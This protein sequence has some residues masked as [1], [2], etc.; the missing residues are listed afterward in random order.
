[1]SKAKPYYDT[2]Y[3]LEVAKMVVE[4]GLTQSQVCQDLSISQSAIARWVRQY[5]SEARG[6]PG[7]GLPLTPEQQRIRALEIEVRQ[8]RE[9]NALLK[10]A[11]AFFA[12]HQK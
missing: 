4:Q 7:I 10:K 11:S 8:L 2:S 5:R 3:K 9:D 1:M 6:E 12:K